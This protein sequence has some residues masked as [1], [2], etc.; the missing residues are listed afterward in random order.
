MFWDAWGPHGPPDCQ[1][2]PRR[3]HLGIPNLEELNDA[4]ALEGLD[5]LNRADLGADLDT[6]EADAEADA[7]ADLELDTGKAEAEACDESVAKKPRVF[8]GRRPGCKDS[9]HFASSPIFH[10]IAFW[11]I[12]ASRG[13]SQSI[14]LEISLLALTFA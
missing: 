2:Y 7:E 1:P 13:G 8:L 11:R 9:S 3:P 5:D 4:D 6:G 12:W 14:L 10:K